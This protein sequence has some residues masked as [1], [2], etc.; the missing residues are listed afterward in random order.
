MKHSS[1]AAQVANPLEILLFHLAGI[2]FG[3]V[4]AQVDA[5][6]YPMPDEHGLTIINIPQR[7]SFPEQEVTYSAARIVWLKGSNSGVMIDNPERMITIDASEIQPL[8]NYLLNRRHPLAYFGAFTTAEDE[9][10][11]LLDLQGLSA[12]E[13][14]TETLSME[15]EV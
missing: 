5:M 11:L 8:A 10:V 12:T 14:I 13:T 7:L 6:T 2:P 9:T 1:T 3:I 4:V 15:D